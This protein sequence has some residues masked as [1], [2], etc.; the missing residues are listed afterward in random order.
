MYFYAENMYLK[1]TYVEYMYIEDNLT[2]TG[3]ARREVSSAMTSWYQ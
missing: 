3:K 2:V 1:H